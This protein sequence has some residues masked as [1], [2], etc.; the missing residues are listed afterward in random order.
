LGPGVGHVTNI[1]NVTLKK[2]V[3]STFLRKM[4]YLFPTVDGATA[5]STKPGI[6]RRKS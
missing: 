3:D 6:L 2:K 5:R 4:D 1:K